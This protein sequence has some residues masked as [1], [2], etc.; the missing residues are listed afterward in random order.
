MVA[1]GAF[2]NGGCCFDY[3]NMETTSRDDSEGT[4]E[5]VYFG[6]CTIWGRGARQ[7]SVGHGRSRERSL[8]GQV[9]ARSPPTCR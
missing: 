2:Y 6:T 5:A 9:A 8:G 3:G 4:M 7:R 1:G